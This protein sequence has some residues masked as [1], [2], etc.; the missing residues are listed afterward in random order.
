LSCIRKQLEAICKWNL[1]LM[2]RALALP[3]IVVKLVSAGEFCRELNSDGN[4]PVHTG[5]PPLKYDVLTGII[6]PQFG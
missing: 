4:L 1:S 6:R 3:V 5:H 2:R